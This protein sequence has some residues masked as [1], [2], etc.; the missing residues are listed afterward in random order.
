MLD[1][2]THTRSNG[3]VHAPPRPRWLWLTLPLVVLGGGASL[4]GIFIDRV[5]E[6]ETA[7]W[8]AQAVGQD[9]TNLV[10][11][12]AL[13]VFATLAVRGSLRAYLLWLGGLAYGVYA[14][15]I[16]AFSIG[17]GPLFLVYV[18]V[19]GLCVFGL[20]GGT[21][22]LDPRLVR[23]RFAA[24]SPVRLTAWVLIG[25]AVLFGLLWLSEILPPTFDGTLP[26]SLTEAGLRVNPVYVLDL[27]VMLPS[28]IVTGVFLLRGRSWGWVLAPV[29][30]VALTLIALG[31]ELAMVVLSA[32]DLAVAAVPVVMVGLIG[33]TQLVVLKRF[34]G[35]VERDDLAGA[36]T[37]EGRSP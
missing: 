35:V 13:A 22:W 14:F 7:N 11:F 29:Q 12:T 20:V 34:L 1:L 26:E 18:C 23:D 2:D 3:R 15:A 10:A 16:Y 5:Y 24:G 30:L 37:R 19:L 17:F 33:F 9:L 6:D 21:L 31:I 25:I 8:A 36:A 32:R 27:A 28:L 4:A